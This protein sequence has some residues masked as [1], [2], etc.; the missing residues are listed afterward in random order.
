MVRARPRMP[1]ASRAR[2]L[3]LALPHADAPRAVLTRC[4]LRAAA[5]SQAHRPGGPARRAAAAAGR[6]AQSTLSRRG[7]RPPARHHSTCVCLPARACPPP[8]RG[9]RGAA[10]QILPRARRV[11]HTCYHACYHACYERVTCV[12]HTSRGRTHGMRALRQPVAA[13]RGGAALAARLRLAV[14]PTCSSR[15]TRASAQLPARS[16]P[17]HVRGPHGVSALTAGCSP[18]RAGFLCL[19]RADRHTTACQRPSLRPP[20]CRARM[21]C[22]RPLSR[23]STA[24]AGH[25]TSG[26]GGLSPR[27]SIQLH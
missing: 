24:L 17:L 12:S 2:G 7:A 25:A 23:A 6:S 16:C 21:R 1:V 3:R 27:P 20:C 11:S 18:R 10:L 22:R 15:S 8:T 4:P 14:L 5:A 13:H 26:L 19:A 9:P